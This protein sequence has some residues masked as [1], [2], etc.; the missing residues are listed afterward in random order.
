MKKT[1]TAFRSTLAGLVII[2]STMLNCMLVVLTIPFG[3]KKQYMFARAWANIGHYA[4][5]GFA[6]LDYEIKGEENLPDTPSVV[7]MKHQSAWETMLIFRIVPQFVIVLKREL[8]AIPVFGHAL[9]SLKFID[10]DRSSGASAVSQVIEK[11]TERLNDGLWVSI[12]PEGTR[13]PVGQTR[14]FGKSGVL[15]AKEANA[16]LVLIAHNAG[17]FWGGKS[18]MV[19]PGKIKVIIGEPIMPEGKTADEMLEEATAWMENTMRDNFPLYKQKAEA[20]AITQAKNDAE[21]VQAKQSA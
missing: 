8:M 10:I 19:H 16:P 7:L 21:N 14:R 20:F 2:P 18:L 13:M 15:L 4:L 1:F 9:S 17:E 12:F 5:I 11:G 3:H 6:G